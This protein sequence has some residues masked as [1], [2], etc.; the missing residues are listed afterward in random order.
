MQVRFVGPQGRLV[1]SNQ[2]AEI[3]LLTFNGLNNSQQILDLSEL[4]TFVADVRR[5]ALGDYL[6]YPNYTNLAANG[7]SGN[8]FWKLPRQFFPTVRLARTNIITGRFV[9]PNDF[10]D[11]ARRFYSLM[12][13]NNEGPGTAN[14]TVFNFGISNLF[15][16]Y[17]LNFVGSGAQSDGG[18]PNRICFLPG[19]VVETIITAGPTTNSVTNAVSA[20]FRNTNGVDRMS[21]FALSDAAG[22][23]G[24]GSG[25]NSIVDFS[26]GTVNALVDRLYLSRGRTNSANANVTAVLTVG[27]GVFDANTAILGFQDQGNNLATNEPPQNGFSC[28]GT[29]NLVSNA[30][31]KVNN[32]LELGY[33]TQNEGAT[34]GN[35][36]AGFGQINIGSNATLM[37]NSILIGGVTKLSGNNTIT[38]TGGDL[39]VSNKIATSDKW[40]TSFT[41]N[42]ASTLTLHL[43]GTNTDYY[44]YVTNLTSSGGLNALN[45]GSVANLVIPPEG[46]NVPIFIHKG[47]VGAADF[48]IVTMPSPMRGAVVQG[49]DIDPSTHTAE[50]TIIT[51]EPKNLVWRGSG[52]TDTWNLTTKNWLDTATGLL[53]NYIN[54]DAVLF[55]DLAGAADNIIVTNTLIPDSVVVSNSSGGNVFVLSG[56]GSIVGTSLVKNGNGSLAID[57]TASIPVLLNNGT[58]T[59]VGLVSSVTVASGATLNFSGTISPSGVICAG[60]AILRGSTVGPLNIQSSGVVTNAD[61]GTTQ[62]PITT[63]SGALLYNAGHLGNGGVGIGSSTIVSN[64]T[65][66]NAGNIGASAVNS[67]LAISGIFRE[68][69]VIGKDI[70]LT[71]LDING[72]VGT[73]NNNAG[74]FIPGGDGIGVTTIKSPGI[75]GVTFSGRVRFGVGSTNIFKVDTAT[76]NTVLQATWIDYG[77]SIG[78]PG[79][80]GGFIWLTNVGA[81]PFAAGQR[82]GLFKY[83]DGTLP[84]QFGSTNSY[85]LMIPTVPGPALA[86][87]LSDVKMNGNVGIRSYSTNLT[88]ITFSSSYTLVTNLTSTNR[89]IVLTLQWPSSHIGGWHVEEQT[90]TRAVGIQ[91][92]ASNWAPIFAS[93][94]TNQ[95]NV[96]NVIGAN[97]IGFYRLVSP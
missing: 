41:L 40:L 47:N 64:A 48:P 13:A 29:V 74:T 94:F 83:E 6:A 22:V 9:D 91:M 60:T 39:I 65:F 25:V 20:F 92:G 67:S 11:P 27:A 50:L 78:N 36:N 43:N 18:V 81:G 59:G 49:P 2:N 85:P 68:M 86:W 89:G 37:A 12:L 7:Y 3:D 75:A 38:V 35:A 28:Q 16:L 10:M 51:N 88:N 46:T 69:G 30:V 1:V 71:L 87:D 76:T 52:L 32:T 26:A 95:I 31:F 97:N 61:T 54:G 80:E 72:G 4:G 70:Y 45:I 33:T 79:F 42:N 77:P 90:S 44:V 17:S 57:G 23:G 66:I 8:A 96:T 82:F 34:N 24:S 55:D 53:T 93:Y 15:K 19:L 21:L 84:I 58:L 56:S 63:Q 5:L 73:N 62:G 14:N